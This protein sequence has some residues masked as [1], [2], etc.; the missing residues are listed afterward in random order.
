MQRSRR[1]DV[2]CHGRLLGVVDLP[3]GGNRRFLSFSIF[4][5]SVIDR[6]EAATPVG[7]SGR[8]DALKPE[9]DCGRKIDA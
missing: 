7:D 4:W 1:H 2:G 3:L 5:L 9:S 6:V 8:E